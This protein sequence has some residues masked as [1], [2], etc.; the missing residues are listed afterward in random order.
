[1][2][3]VRSYKDKWLDSMRRVANGPNG[4]VAH[5]DL[6]EILRHCTQQSWRVTMRLFPK[7][8][9]NFDNAQV[10]PNDDLRALP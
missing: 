3:I 5:I 2:G 1:M 8:D 9:Y 6:P 4:M 10:R 7:T